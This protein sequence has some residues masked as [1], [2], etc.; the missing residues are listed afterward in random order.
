MGFTVV[1]QNGTSDAEFEA[2]ARLLRQHGVDLGKLPRVR[3]PITG[4]R[5][6]YVWNTKPEA[7]AFAGELQRHTRDGTWQVVPAAAPVSEGP[8]GPLIIRLASQGDGLAFDLHPLSRALIRSA[9]PDAFGATLLFVDTATWND[10]RRTQRTLGDLTRER[11][12]PTLTGLT[13]DQ[14]QVLGYTVTDADTGETLVFTPPVATV[15]G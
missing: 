5:W 6:L 14:L 12:A 1:G 11:I 9:F 8:L 13:D 10:F 2:Y 7:E 15:Q 3:D 4:K